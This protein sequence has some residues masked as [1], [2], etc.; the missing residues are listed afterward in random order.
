[1]LKCI[2]NDVN[3]F[4]SLKTLFPPKITVRLSRILNISDIGTIASVVATIL[5]YVYIIFRISQKIELMRK[6]IPTIK[7]QKINNIPKTVIFDEFDLK[8]FMIT[9]VILNFKI[10]NLEFKIFH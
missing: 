7:L 2:S 9:R 4:L 1:M 8:Y 3:F 5:Y 6:K 10:L